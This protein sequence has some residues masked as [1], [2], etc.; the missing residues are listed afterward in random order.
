[1]EGSWFCKPLNFLDA[2]VRFGILQSLGSLFIGGSTSCKD[3]GLF[4]CFCWPW[5][6]R[7]LVHILWKVLH[8]VRVWVCLDALASLLALGPRSSFCGRFCILYGFG[9]VWVLLL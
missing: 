6:F 3:L 7:A 2:L 4:G 9:F 5:D 1:M 8:F